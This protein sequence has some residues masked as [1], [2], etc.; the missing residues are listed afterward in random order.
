MG[1]DQG[2]TVSIFF[3]LSCAFL[4]KGGIEAA[5]INKKLN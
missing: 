2:Q 5:E 1:P 4:N 3:C